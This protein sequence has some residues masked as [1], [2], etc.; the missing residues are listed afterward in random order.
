[1]KGGNKKTSTF[2]RTR[3]ADPPP[4]PYLVR[5]EDNVAVPLVK[6]SI[7]LFGPCDNFELGEIG[8]HGSGRGV[9]GKGGTEGVGVDGA[10]FR[11]VR[12]SLHYKFPTCSMRQIRISTRSPILSHAFSPFGDGERW[13]GGWGGGEGEREREED[14]KGSVKKEN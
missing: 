6:F 7:F 13:V 12:C 5:V 8:V 3:A 1:V 10:M 9:D 4:S 14:S 11:Y 2:K